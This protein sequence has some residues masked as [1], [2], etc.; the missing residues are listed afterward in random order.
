MNSYIKSKIRNKKNRSRTKARLNKSKNHYYGMKFNSYESRIQYI[1]QIYDNHFKYLFDK[2]VTEYSENTLDELK[3]KMNL[4]DGFFTE[5][6]NISSIQPLD[7]NYHVKDINTLCFIQLN[8]DKKDDFYYTLKIYDNQAI[9]KIIDLGRYSDTELFNLKKIYNIDNGFFT[10]EYDNEPLSEHLLVKNI[11][12]LCFKKLYTYEYIL[13]NNKILSSDTLD[14]E[15]LH[16]SMIIKI[17]MRPE[18]Y[19]KISPYYNDNKLDITITKGNHPVSNL[20][21][22]FILIGTISYNSIHNI[23]IP[24]PIHSY[25]NLYKPGDVWSSEI[26][27]CLDHTG[28]YMI[29][30]KDLNSTPDFILNLAIQVY[31]HR[32]KVENTLQYNIIVDNLD[33]YYR[34]NINPAPSLQTKDLYRLEIMNPFPVS[35]NDFSL[36]CNIIRMKTGEEIY[37]IPSLFSKQFDLEYKSII[38]KTKQYMNTPLFNSKYDLRNAG[39]AISKA[40]GEKLSGDFNSLIEKRI[41]F[42]LQ[43]EFPI[44]NIFK[45]FILYISKQ[46]KAKVTSS[47]TLG[48]NSTQLNIMENNTYENSNIGIHSDYNMTTLDKSFRRTILLYINLLDTEVIGFSTKITKTI[49]TDLSEF[50][51]QKTID[52]LNMF[53]QIIN[54][55]NI[56]QFSRM[57][58]IFIKYIR[59]LPIEKELYA[60]NSVY[61]TKIE[62]INSSIPY[63]KNLSYILDVIPHIDKSLIKENY[64]LNFVSQNF[65]LIKFYNKITNDSIISLVSYITYTYKQKVYHLIRELKSNLDSSDPRYKVF[66]LVEK[67][68]IPK[69]LGNTDF[70][71]K[72]SYEPNLTS[73]YHVLYKNDPL[74]EYVSDFNKLKYFL[75][76]NGISPDMDLEFINPNHILQYK[77][78]I[79]IGEACHFKDGGIVYFNGELNHTIDTGIGKRVSIVYKILFEDEMEDTDPNYIPLLEREK[80]FFIEQ[81]RLTKEKRIEE[82]RV[83]KQNALGY[84]P[85]KRQLSLEKK[86][87]LMRKNSL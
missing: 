84:N 77:H 76:R 41:F 87:M 62:N 64:F 81:E 61:K 34:M 75:F 71:I 80:R 56:V 74:Y 31:K 35:M 11:I 51:I 7:D 60:Y 63:F 19:D 67:I 33:Y 44:M 46:I 30:T 45:N 73:S 32:N 24:K 16:N 83:D 17:K 4:G 68:M 28:F 37:C 57:G 5:Y 79:V 52:K 18:F 72:F 59:N 48:I 36:S 27:V 20:L 43:D 9:H 22:P 14:K 85:I 3:L 10:T 50:T 55:P 86:S 1:L 12:K 29:H 39:T 40:L 38:K 21:L 66:N 42:Y 49:D 26:L 69:K 2:N 78:D 53:E 54:H 25:Y 8:I 15:L 23:F 82:A 70:F 47:L 65:E 58:N 6:D 13:H